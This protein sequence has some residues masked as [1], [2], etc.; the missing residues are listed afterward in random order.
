MLIPDLDI[1]PFQGLDARGWLQLLD[2]LAFFGGVVFWGHFFAVFDDEDFVEEAFDAGAV[3]DNLGI[4]EVVMQVRLGRVAGVA[5]QTEQLALFDSVAGIDTDAALFEMGQDRDFAVLVFDDDR[6][7]QRGVGIHRT[8]GIVAD[9][10]DDVS[11]D[12]VGGSEDFLAECVII[13]VFEA[14]VFMALTLSVGDDEVEGI[15]LVLRVVVLVQFLGI[16]APNHSPLVLE[17]QPE[18]DCALF[19][20]GQFGFVRQEPQAGDFVLVIQDNSHIEQ[21]AFEMNRIE[22]DIAGFHTR[23]A[24]SADGAELGRESLEEG[25]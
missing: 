25:L 3:L 9:A 16:A 2:N 5:A 11:D 24:Q 19:R 1:P 12:A 15:L 13:F 23:V 20:D 10:A 22:H 17:G 14:V 21:A 6:I 4:L 7:A 18:R 8:G